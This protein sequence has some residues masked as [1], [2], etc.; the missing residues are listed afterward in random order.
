MP[1]LPDLLAE[2]PVGERSLLELR[3]TWHSLPDA[4]ARVAACL[5]VFVL[6]WDPL[7]W[8][9]EPF[10]ASAT[11]T[12]DGDDYEVVLY[13]PLPGAAAMLDDLCRSVVDVGVSQELL[14]SSGAYAQLAFAGKVPD[15]LSAVGTLSATELPQFELAHTGWEPIGLGAIEDLAQARF[16]PVDLDRS[17]VRFEVAAEPQPACPACAGRRFGFPAELADGL[18]SMCAPHA[19]QAEEVTSARLERAEASNRE[20]WRAIVDASEALHQPTYGLPLELLGR[21][22][23]AVDR[24]DPSLDELRG[25]AATALDL[26][27]RLRGRD[28]DFENW[29]DDWMARDWM[30]ELPWM[31][32]R[33]E[34]T[35]E[36]VQVADAFAELDLE[37]DS[38]YAADASVMLAEAG[39]ADEARARVHANLSA[40]PQDIWTHVHAGDVHRSLDDPEQA[41][42]AF[43]RAVALAQAHGDQQDTA[44]VTRR[45]ADL[46][47]TVA[48]RES[49]AAEA[50]AIA[51]RALAVKRGQ[52]VVAKTGRNDPC[53]CGS[54]RKFKKCCGA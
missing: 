30:F 21:L 13:A 2:A 41:E 51:E 12:G 14:L 16:G 42:Q 48:G 31:L 45:L 44:I 25:D 52:R 20:G 26:A 34:M 1:T 43:R 3:A 29:A 49:D 27:G 11:A 9:G 54:S 50:A 35:V 47:A 37:H 46:L 15:L 17:A 40:F 4:H 19:G 5:R 53:P 24:V 6:N 8:L 7:G 18:A 39:Y 23:Q 22:E 36:A 10:A 32:A 38:A 28:A 33:R